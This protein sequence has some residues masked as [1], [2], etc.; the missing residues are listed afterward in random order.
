MGYQ[1]PKRK[2][3]ILRR[4]RGVELRWGRRHIPIARNVVPL[5]HAAGLVAGELHGNAVGNVGADHFLV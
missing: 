2:L 4:R 5:E 3:D 1:A